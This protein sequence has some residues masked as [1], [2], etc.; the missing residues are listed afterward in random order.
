[1]SSLTRDGDEMVLRCSYSQ[2]E[3][4]K[5]FPGYKWDKQ[6]RVWRY[7][8]HPDVAM[9][10]RA[11]LP[12]LQIERG[13][14]DTL[15]A[16]VAQHREVVKSKN[17]TDTDVSWSAAG[18]LRAYQRVGVAWL[19]DTTG[20]ILADDMGCGKTVQ[21]I[22]AC[23]V[24][25]ARRI[26]IVTPSAVRWA[27][28][29]EIAAW[30]GDDPTVITGPKD[31]RL[32]AITGHG[33][34]WLVATYDH[35]RMHP[36][37][38]KHQWDAVVFDEA[39]RIKNRKAA[40]AKAAMRLRTTRCYLLTGTPMLN[41]ADELYNMLHRLDK[42][43]WRSYWQFAE[44]F[45]RLDYNG[46]GVEVLPGS[47]AQQA[48]LVGVLA[49]IMLR[50]TKEQVLPELPPKVHER[51]VIGMSPEQAKTYRRMEKDALMEL[52]DG[53]V[54]TAEVVIAQVTRLRQIALSP[55]LVDPNSVEKGRK[56]AEAVRL[57]QEQMG[58]H[59][60][61][62]FSQFRSAIELLESE[63]RM[64]GI[65][66]V[67]VTGSVPDQQRHANTKDLQSDPDT[68]VML[69]TIAAAGVGLTWTAADTCIFLDRHW[70]PAVNEQAEDRL[71][72][73]GQRG[74]VT[75]I[76]MVSEGTVEESIAALLDEKRSVVD[77]IVEGSID[78]QQVL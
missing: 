2:R 46:Y 43:R 24:A 57:I 14:A 19:A 33:D 26:L 4:A 56:I 18:K 7:P 51:N 10:I 22:A 40:Q 67:S 25:G 62:V 55:K 78:V 8:L 75:V 21:A 9:Q 49:P 77:A 72:R 64:R 23:Q 30:T 32:Q 66:S 31:E 52:Q 44:R 69:A 29:E 41:K 73:M 28:G 61:V 38:A 76:D 63:L 45:C 6:N 68:R 71:H 50:R 37:L 74:S 16:M 3:Q 34:G 53:D 48:D 54:L 59:K 1:M 60:I 42:R 17:A 12:G 65:A 15:N 27:W 20:A 5:G 58:E 36:E 13:L 35:L 39:H 47:A 11:G 70:T